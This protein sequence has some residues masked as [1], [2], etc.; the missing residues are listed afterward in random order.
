[1]NFKHKWF[2]RLLK[3]SL[4]VTYAWCFFSKRKNNSLQNNKQ[5][6]L[7]YETNAKNNHNFILETLPKL[8]LNSYW[9]KCITIVKL[10][11]SR[12]LK[13]ER[14]IFTNLPGSKKR[15]LEILIIKG[16]WKM[17]KEGHWSKKRPKIDRVYK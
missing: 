9:H 12:K 14:T 7:F 15:K 1:M 4:M 17:K 16:E 13:R 10:M 2:H 5:N 3:P 11:T 6:Y 8:I